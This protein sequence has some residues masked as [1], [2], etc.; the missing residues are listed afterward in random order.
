MLVMTVHKGK[1]LEF[2]FDDGTVSVT[3]KS[4]SRVTGS[5]EFEIDGPKTMS[6]D[7]PFNLPPDDDCEEE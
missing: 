2:E 5:V 3:L 6:I 1:T 4:I 7:T